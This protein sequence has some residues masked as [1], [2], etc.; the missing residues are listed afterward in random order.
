MKSVNARYAVFAFLAIV[1]IATLIFGYNQYNSLQHEKIE[2]IRDHY[3]QVILEKISLI[4]SQMGL[5][6]TSMVSFY[7]NSETVTVD[8]Y[9]NYAQKLLEEIPEVKNVFYLKDDDIIQSYPHTEFINSK[10][11][12]L[13]PTFPITIDNAGLMAIDYVIDDNQKIVVA[14]PF[15]LILHGKTILDDNYKLVLYDQQNSEKILFQ[16]GVINGKEITGPIE[17]TSQELNSVLRIQKQTDLHGDKIKQHYI[18]NYLVWSKQLEENRD[19]FTQL[20][21]VGGF[22]FAIL[23]PLLLIKTEQYRARAQEHSE[24]LDLVNKRLIDIDRQKGEF[25]SMMAHELKTPLV[26]I[27]GNVD[28]LK[29]PKMIDKLDSVQIE[30]I[31]SIEKNARRL[32]VLISDLLDAQKIHLNRM[33]FNK[34]TFD[35][36]EFME[37]VRTNLDH[38]MK[39]KQITFVNNTP[40]SFELVADENRLRQVIGNLVKNS[41]DFVAEGG[42]IEIGATVSGNKAQFY[43]KD[44]GIG[45]PQ[46][47]QQH[48]FKKFYQADTSIRRRHGGTGLGL[49]ICKGIVQGLGGEIWFESKEGKGTTFYF[50]I[51]LEG[52][53]VEVST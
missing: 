14:I 3:K 42:K 22:I 2:V 27:L 34:S 26:P 44:N 45:I 16:T 36:K 39:E 23:I 6:G 21:F 10:F 48:L 33:K 30:T 37:S 38:Y 4:E 20:V 31:D 43:V 12:S 32:E 41:V 49:V 47:K 19:I 13:F 28:F 8:E 53:K 46:E 40:A 50:S 18:L 5:F 25:S 17:F 1:M 7:E 35:V 9:N 51:P 11:D 29:S 15:S 52:Q 24:V